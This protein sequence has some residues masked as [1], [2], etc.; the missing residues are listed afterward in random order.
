[1]ALVASAA[2]Q[3]AKLVAKSRF[4]PHEMIRKKLPDGTGLL[5]ELPTRAKSTSEDDDAADKEYCAA[6]DKVSAVFGKQLRAQTTADEHMMY[7]RIFDAWLMREGF[8]SYFEV[9]LEHGRCIAVR[10]RRRPSGEKKVIKPQMLVGYLLQMAVGGESA[11]K[12]GHA[13]DLAARAATE[14]ATACGKRSSMTRS[15]GKFGFG[16]YKDE[17]WSLQAFQKRV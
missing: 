11:P 13:A 15:K 8:G 4:R 14:V 17:P 1:M 7:T 16:G 5:K 6:I 10:A 9:D 12:G 2:A 3:K